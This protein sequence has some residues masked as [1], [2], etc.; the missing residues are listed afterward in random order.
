ENAYK[1]IPSLGVPVIP[2]SHPLIV[3]NL[4]IFRTLEGIS[5]YHLPT[6]QKAWESR[7]DV[8]LVG[9]FQNQANNDP[10]TISYL[11]TY[12]DHAPNI[13]VEN[14]LLGT[15]GADSEL[16][17]SVEDTAVP[18][19]VQV[20]G[21][22]WRGGW[23]RNPQMGNRQGDFASCN[24]LIAYELEGG[25]IAWSIGTRQPDQPFTDMFFLGPPLPLGGKL[26]VLAEVNAEIKLL[27][28]QN[29]KTPKPNLPEEFDYAVELVW[30]QP[31][32]VVDRKLVEDPVRRTQA[33]MLSY[34]DGILVC[35]TN[36]GT[37]LGV[38]LLT[39]TLVWAFNFQ[40]EPVNTDSNSADRVPQFR[41]LNRQQRGV[42]SITRGAQWSYSAPVIANG[43][44]LLA[45]PDGN[46][47]HAIHLR[48]GNVNWSNPRV[49]LSKDAL[50]PD[51][52]LAGTFEDVALLV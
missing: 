29:I 47:L 24:H 30:A 43:T 1:R 48:D 36:A 9:V 45:L 22:P 28:L 17:Y 12:R 26:Y 49:D 37:V 23:N 51:Y 15:L 32:G 3:E 21:V 41:I 50:P 6:G 46:A 25:R 40:N 2:G 52:Y 4:V 8:S 19:N 42:E 7:S 39:R 11:A 31:L 10:E 5:A 18:P 34:S 16:V 14:T 33:A 35:P 38:D 27:C 44:V 13:L 20:H